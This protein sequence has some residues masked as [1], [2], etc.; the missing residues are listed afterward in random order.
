MERSRVE[1][2]RRNKSS[3]PQWHLFRFDQL[4]GFTSSLQGPGAT[5]AGTGGAGQTMFPGLNETLFEALGRHIPQKKRLAIAQLH[6][7]HLV[8]IAIKDFPAPADTQ[9]RSAHQPLHGR[10]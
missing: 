9:R 8:E 5:A 10:G 1:G 7:E 3:A 6:S 4:P 2:A